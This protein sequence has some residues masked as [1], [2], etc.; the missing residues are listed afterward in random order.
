MI[1]L[2]CTVEFYYAEN[3]PI[4]KYEAP[5]TQREI[6]NISDINF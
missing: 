1:K 4:T 6:N 5:S 2:H 3:K